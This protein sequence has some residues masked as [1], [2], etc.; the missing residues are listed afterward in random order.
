MKDPIYLVQRATLQAGHGDMNSR[1]KWDHMGSSEFEFGTLARSIKAMRLL[2]ETAGL[3]ETE[4]DEAGFHFWYIGPETRRH[5]A[6]RLINEE[7]TGT[8]VRRL[9]ATRMLVSFMGER[10]YD[11]WVAVW[12]RYPPGMTQ[13]PDM[14][15]IPFALFRSETAAL[16]FAQGLRARDA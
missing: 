9:E 6:V 10:D 7:M 15:H 2:D 3:L 5:E 1:F 8:R 13:C 14:A 11:T 16:S 12:D 4:I